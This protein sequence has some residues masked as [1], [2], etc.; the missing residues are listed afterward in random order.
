MLSSLRSPGLKIRETL[1]PSWGPRPTKSGMVQ[2]Y[3]SE[4]DFFFRLRS[5]RAA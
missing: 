4:A 3:R 5:L 1:A 2:P